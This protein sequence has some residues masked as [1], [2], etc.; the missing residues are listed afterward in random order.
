MYGSK[1]YYDPGLCMATFL[2]LKEGIAHFYNDSKSKISKC[3]FKL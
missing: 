3:A 2:M 1:S